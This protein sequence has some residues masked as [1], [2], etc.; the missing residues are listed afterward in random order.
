MS[1]PD[2]LLTCPPRFATA[3]DESRATRGG[4]VAKVAEALGTPLMPWQRYV[5]DVAMEVDNRTGKLAYRE[6]V[7]TVPRQSGKTTLILALMVHRALMIDP[8][9]R[10]TYTAQTR[11]DARKKWED[12]HI[13]TLKASL[14]DGQFTVRKMIGSEAIMWKN[15][16]QHGITSTTEKAGHGSTLDLGVIDE[17][18]ALVDARV[19]QAM[20]PATITRPQPQIVICSTAG[21]PSSIYLNGKIERGRARVR[22]GKPSTSAYFEWSAADDVDLSDPATWPTFM[23]AIGYS[24]TVEAVQSQ[25]DSLELAEF[26]R[27]YGNRCAV[28]DSFDPVIP[29]DQ[30]DSL[31]DPSSRLVDP[32]VFGVDVSLS[33][34]NACI[35]AVGA[36][37]AGVPH[38][39]VVDVRPGT[40]WLVG[41]LA[42]L[43]ARWGPSAI[44]IDNQGPGVSLID[45]LR[46][47]DVAVD[48]TS[49]RD[50]AAACGRFF[51]VAT[52]GG[53]VHVG[54]EQL[55]LALAGAGQR[56]LGDAWAWSRKRSAVDIGPIVAATLALWS[57]EQRGRVAVPSIAF[58]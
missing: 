35:V 21:T 14:F 19:E 6:V 41:R 56:D 25:F 32:V 44:V 37:T 31:A 58:I 42:E 57:F 52:N 29:L 12:D 39:E 27:A 22:E 15:G 28:E 49:W 16:S 11:L 38:V 26:A 8:P 20:A 3:R 43:V 23:P 13:Q 5:A 46:G 30:W 17:A 50:M 2:S 47:L 34:S 40:S 53:L 10:I 45:E 24:Q 36:N 48:V 18:F 51:D 55:R 54:Q 9:A 33:R 7:L 4:E 1:S